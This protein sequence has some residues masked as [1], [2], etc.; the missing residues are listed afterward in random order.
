MEAAAGEEEAERQLFY[1]KAVNVYQIP[2]RESAS[3]GYRS[4]RCACPLARSGISVALA[5]FCS[6]ISR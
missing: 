5:V 6:C 2:P 3:R 1:G 4:R